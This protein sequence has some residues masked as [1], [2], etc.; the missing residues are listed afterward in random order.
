VLIELA[1]RDRAHLKQMMRPEGETVT[2]RFYHQAGA[3][4]PWVPDEVTISASAATDA[5]GKAIYQGGATWVRLMQKAFT[6]FAGRHGKYGDALQPRAERAEYAQIEVGSSYRLFNVFYGESAKGTRG[7]ISYDR[8]RADLG[9]PLEIA[10]Q[11]AAF[12]APAEGTR[13]FLTASSSAHGLIV[14]AQSE[15]EGLPNVAEPDQAKLDAFRTTLAE[16]E[17]ALSQRP[18]ADEASQPET[19]RV[20]QAAATLVADVLGGYAHHPR[21]KA[22]RELCLDLKDIG[23]DAGQDPRF[24]YSAHGYAIV[25]VKLAMRGAKPAPSRF[26]QTD[27]AEL[28]HEAS[29]ITL[30]NP[31]RQNEPEGAVVTEKGMFELTL[32]QF[33][34]NYTFLDQ[35]VVTAKR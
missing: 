22:L 27:L 29:R 35:G 1:E 24:V 5:A 16:A 4:A 26:T 14:H 34:R 31:H 33:V 3:N 12:V 6:V 15:M 21:F 25:G 32:A 23:T 11:L 7:A 10:D 17:T 13:T 20:K 9:I 30:R 19:L 8:S 18:G 2:V 28:D